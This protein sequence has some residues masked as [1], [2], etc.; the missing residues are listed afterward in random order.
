MTTTNATKV[1]AEPGRQELF[2][3][4]EFD[5]SREQVFTAFTDPS[6]LVIFFAPF[7]HSMHF[8]YHNY[9]SGGS[10]S[11]YNKNAAGKVLC[12]FNGVIHELTAPVRVIQ[13]AEFM[14]LPERGHTVMEA[15]LFEELEGG[16]TK[17]TIHDV[18]F[19][20]ADRDAMI[21][22]GMEKG[23]ADIF[24]QLDL[25]LKPGGNE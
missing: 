23:L 13:T 2:I 5:A 25:L 4:R 10:Y 8:N 9:T 18:C 7:G 20:V 19:S 17:L 3:V 11:W 21:N 22:S 24:N 16:R 1:I 6:I 15:M 12:T 14:E